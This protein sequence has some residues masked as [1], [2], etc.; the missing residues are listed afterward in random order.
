MI[1]PI[2]LIYYCIIYTSA[3]LSG[4]ESI[5]LKWIKSNEIDTVNPMIIPIQII[6]CCTIYASG[7]LNGQAYM[8]V[9]CN[10]VAALEK[11]ANAKTNCCQ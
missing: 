4:H 3:K 7:K 8:P 2:H 5:W 1:L 6:Y 9:P 11:L 10:M